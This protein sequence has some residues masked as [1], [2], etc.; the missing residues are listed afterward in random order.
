MDAP[1]RW[2]SRIAYFVTVALAAGAAAGI[3]ALLLNIRARKDEAQKHVVQLFELDEDTVDPAVWG[4][5]YRSQYDSYKRTVDTQRTKHGGSDAI[6]KL[7]QDPELRRM[8][9]GYAFSI[10][11]REERG[12]AFM[13]KDQDDTERVKQRKQPGACL[14]C[15]SSVIPAYRKLGQGDVSA[16]FT[17]M[18][19]MDWKEARALVSHP[20]TCID[21]H[22]PKNAQLRVSR[23]AFFQGIQAFA[24]GDEP[25]PHLP[26]VER[27]RK[28]NRKKPYDPNADATRQEL[29]SFVCG[30]CHVEYYVQPKTNLLTYPWS[31]GLKAEQIEAYYDEIG[32]K[33]WMHAE[34]A[35]ATL[36]AQHPEFELWSQGIHARS[37]VSCSDC[38]MPYQREGA[39]KVSD[40]HVRSPL[41][42]VSRACQVCHRFDEKE[43]LARAEAIQ[44]RT[45]SLLTRSQ[46][47]LVDLIEALKTAKARGAS[48]KVLAD[49]RALQRRAQWRIDF[50]A[51]ENSLGFHAPQESA[52]LLAEAIDFARL[53]Q[54]AVK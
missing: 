2:R 34:T 43:I 9:A 29:R 44:D 12:H 25:A 26:S 24:A 10:D 6:D 5:Y 50:I 40:H 1:P 11:F 22:D 19:A 53:G 42:N 3:T 4:N 39:I 52:R 38:H 48:E 18:C 36:K 23:P 54:L 7:E 14:H 46:A 33:D 49:A 45:K 15:H 31:K 20:V 30:Q 41:L 16:G 17:A 35:A 13:L 32:F 21:C 37:G 8:Y 51:S 28:G 27:W 47:A